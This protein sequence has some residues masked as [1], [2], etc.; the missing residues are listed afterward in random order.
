MF[1][2]HKQWEDW[3]TGSVSCKCIF[4]VSSAW[5]NGTGYS[6]RR[7]HCC[8][9][10]KQLFSA[11]V[12]VRMHMSA[13]VWD[14]E[15]GILTW[16]WV[17]QCRRAA[18]GTDVQFC[19]V[20]SPPTWFSF[21][22]DAGWWCRLLWILSHSYDWHHKDNDEEPKI[23]FP[24]PSERIIKTQQE[25]KRLLS[26]SVNRDLLYITLPCWIKFSIIK[27]DYKEKSVFDIFITY[28][29]R[30]KPLLLDLI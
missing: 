13:C 24:L 4:L 2:L 14:R 6:I 1:I 25:K 3:E 11:S 29:N 26:T 20:T 23:N 22:T 12:Y 30:I 28:R 9:D 18:A 27:D 10:R 16:L 17:H 15:R 7:P 19:S 5:M 8:L 21:G